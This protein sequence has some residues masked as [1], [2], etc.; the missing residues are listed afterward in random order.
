MKIRTDFVT[1]SSSSSFILARK[2]DFDDEQKEAIID[3]VKNELLGKKI[4]TPESSEEEIQQ[5]F[6]DMIFDEN[7]QDK[8]R[9]CLAKGLSIYSGIVNFENDNGMADIYRD[10][11]SSLSKKCNDRRFQEIDTDLMY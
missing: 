1:N 11:W 8:V 5:V 4:L 3:F 6:E 10:L 2:P 7:T 9:E